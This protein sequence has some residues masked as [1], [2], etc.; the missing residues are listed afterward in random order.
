MRSIATALLL[1]LMAAGAASGQSTQTGSAAM[2][3]TVRIDW[4]Q[5]EVVVDASVNLA[6]I[7]ATLISAR[8]QSVQLIS[9]AL[10]VLIRN[11]LFPVP[12][13]SYYTIKDKVLSQPRLLAALEQVA[14]QATMIDSF[15]DNT[16]EAVTE[17]FRLPLYPYVISVF[18]LDTRTYSPQRPLGFTPSTAYTGIVIYAQGQ[19]PV[20]GEQTQAELVPALFPKVYDDQMNL[21]VEAGMVNADALKKWGMV[22]YTSSTSFAPFRDRIGQLPFITTARQIFG[23][24]RTDLIISSEAAMRILAV[25]KNISLIHEG[26][27]LVICDLP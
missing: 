22:Q 24:Y 9:Q 8:E 15:M 16:L 3:S 6:D 5:Q 19:L 10:P 26:R 23:K 21:I 20:H 1:M 11:A 27:I 2:K 14:A 13:D 25:D 12:F 18:P 4:Q 7:G 17:K